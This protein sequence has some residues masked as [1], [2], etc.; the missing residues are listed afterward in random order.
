MNYWIVK[1]EPETYSFQDLMKDKKTR[2][3]G[4]R[5]YT[6]RNNLRAMK[7][8][9]VVVIYESVGPKAAVGLAKVAK[10]AYQDPQT[11]EDWSAVDLAPTKSLK[12]AVTL[13]DMKA[14][15][16]LRNTKLVKQS[17]LSVAPLTAEEFHQIIK[18]SDAT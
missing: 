7:V 9:D 5:N 3:D 17:R 15:K 10:G 4:V 14:D 18:L 16:I 6:A 12:K 8:G 11:K 2:W 13:A 1:T